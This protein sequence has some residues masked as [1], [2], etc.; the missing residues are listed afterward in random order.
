MSYFDFISSR[1]ARQILS[2]IGYRPI[3]TM[4]ATGFVCIEHYVRGAKFPIVASIKRWWRSVKWWVRLPYGKLF[5]VVAVYLVLI[6]L[7]LLAR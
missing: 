4:D 5:P 1:K 7:L 3:R 6:S 2:R